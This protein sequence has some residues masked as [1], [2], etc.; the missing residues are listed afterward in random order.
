MECM[1]GAFGP[2]VIPET[3]PYPGA[4]GG[5]WVFWGL[6][7]SSTLAVQLSRHLGQKGTII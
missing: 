1:W 2:H 7:L 6:G 3:L 5:A 4:L